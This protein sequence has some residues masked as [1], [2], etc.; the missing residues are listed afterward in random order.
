MSFSSEYD[1]YQVRK[2]F[3]MFKEDSSFIYFD[4]AATSQKPQKVIDRMSQFLQEEYGTVHRAVYAL[5]ASATSRY[6]EVRQKVRRFLDVREDGEIIFTRGTTDGINLVASS[7]GKMFLKEGDEVFISETEHHSNIVPWQIICKERKALLK[8]IP[9]NDQGEILLDVYKKM[10]SSKTKLVA[11][12]HIS[13][14]TGVIH[15]IAEMIRLAHEQ[16]AVVLIDAAQ[17]APHQLISVKDLDMDFLVFSAHKMYGPTG[18]GAL[19]GKKKWLDQMPPYQGGGDMV[20]QVTF[21]ETTY[22]PV[23]LKF[24]AGTPSIVEV[25]GLGAAIEFLEEIGLAKI[26]AYEKMLTEYAF[27]KMKKVKEVTLLSHASN[28]GAIITFYSTKFHSLDIGTLLDIKGIAVRT[29]HLCAQPALARFGIQSAVRISFGMYN[30]LAEIDYFI[31]VLEEVFFL[32]R[33]ESS[34]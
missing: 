16:G 9:V 25:M 1:V 22:Q 27:T 6:D 19:Y 2:E 7:F 28:K 29:G 30:T 15:P 10:L 11:V 31:K 26:E 24:E 5:A 8:V 23:P 32:L 3:P 21:E 17:S 4:S 20:H 12:A 14:A 33:D 18:V 34:L 13:N